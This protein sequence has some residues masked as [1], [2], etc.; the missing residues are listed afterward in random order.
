[1]AAREADPKRRIHVDPDHGTARREPQL[2]L[3]GEQHV[4]DF[5]LLPELR[6]LTRQEGDGRVA[7]RLLGL[8]NGVDGMSRE[9]AARQ[10]GLDR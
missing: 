4:P 2:P 5:V 7:C 8:A 10:P 9:R 6:R 3:A 1:M